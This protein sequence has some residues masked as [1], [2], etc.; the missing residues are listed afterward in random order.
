MW[1]R[2]IFNTRLSDG[3]VKFLLHM[4]NRTALCYGFQCNLTCIHH[5]ICHR[6]IRASWREHSITQ[7]FA[8]LMSE[9]V[10]FSSGYP[11]AFATIKVELC[12]ES[13]TGMPVQLKPR[14]MA[15]TLISILIN[16]KIEC[17]VSRFTVVLFYSIYK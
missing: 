6:T 11:S 9:F 7:L 12:K 1:L 2:A 3:T 17:L 8:V 13:S 14:K 15:A 16:Q 4:V 5:G 10:E